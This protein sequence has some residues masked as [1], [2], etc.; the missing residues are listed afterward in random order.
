V[1]ESIFANLMDVFFNKELVSILKEKKGKSQIYITKLQST[2]Q[3][4]ISTRM[5]WTT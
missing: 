5:E 2:I 3:D 1:D 4:N